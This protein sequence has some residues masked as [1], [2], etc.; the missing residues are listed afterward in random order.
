MT[1]DQLDFGSPYTIVSL[2]C[3]PIDLCTVHHLNKG[4]D[5]FLYK[6][7]L[8]RVEEKIGKERGTFLSHGNVDDL[9]EICALQTR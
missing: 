6:Q 2:V 8:I 7:Y 4:S 9:L 3:L 1:R 5:K